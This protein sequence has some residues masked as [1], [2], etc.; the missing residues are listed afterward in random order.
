MPQDGPG[1]RGPDTWDVILRGC[2]GTWLALLAGMTR[3]LRYVTPGQIVEVT[4]RTIQSRFLLRP[5]DE[6]NAAILAVLGRARAHHDVGLHGFAVLSNHAHFLLTVADG[7]E[8]AS[9][10]RFVNRNISCAVG[11]LHDWRGPVWAWRYRSIPVVDEASQMSR[12]TYL[13][14]Q[15]C[16][17][18]LVSSP[19]AWPGLHCA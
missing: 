12:M 3:P 13:L 4:T 5:S 7:R 18:G 9:F 10:M 11:R 15:G 14:R 8:L 2:A 19:L 16:K 1:G 17:E 6:L